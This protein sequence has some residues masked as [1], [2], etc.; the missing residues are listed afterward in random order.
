MW[1]GRR[2]RMIVDTGSPVSV[3]PKSVYKKHCKWWPALQKTPIRLSCFLGP[4]PVWGKVEMKVQLGPVTVSSSLIVVDHQG[5][6]LCGRDTIEEF[7]KAGVFL[8]ERGMSSMVNVVHVDS[9]LT[10]LLDEFSDC[11]EDLGCCKGPPVKL[12]LKEG[13]QPRFLKARTV[14]Y[15]MR[16][17]VSAEID[18]LVEVG[19]LSPVSV[20]EW[21]TPV[22]P[23]VKKNGDIRLCGDF[24]LTVNPATRTEQYPLPKIEDIF[25]TLAGGEVF[26]TLDLRNAY[27]QLPLD[28]DAKKIAVLNTHKGLFGYNR[29]AFGIAS[30]PALFQRRIEAVL[31]ALPGVKVYLDDII[32]AEK[33]QNT[34]LLRQVLER[35]RANGLTLNKEKCRFRE[36]EVVF[37]GHRI[38]ARGLHPLQDNLE[39]VLAAPPPT[40]NV[41]DHTSKDCTLQQ[42]KTWIL[43][44]WPKRLGADEQQYQPYFARRQ[45]LTVSKGIL[46]EEPRALDFLVRA[47]ASS[48]PV[49]EEPF[50]T[51]VTLE[52]SSPEGPL[53]SAGDQTTSSDALQAGQSVPG[54]PAS[55]GGIEPAVSGPTEPIQLRRSTR[56]CKPPDRF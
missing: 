38:D 6:L 34:T 28:D 12:Y 24:K 18:R 17:Q 42:V 11:F 54:E 30:A 26:S 53:S 33:A 4:L 15:A 56:A 50:E 20:A 19:V 1:E 7:R 46:N 35:L 13:A 22:V 37:L 44:G 10:A 2:L 52:H 45:E 51:P 55:G 36:K 25:A 43:Q 23:V 32:V 49:K 48:T 31:Q 9:K 41:S 14:P 40:S 8:L 47:R 27:N 21:A 29:L 16:A 3:I 5:P 39:A